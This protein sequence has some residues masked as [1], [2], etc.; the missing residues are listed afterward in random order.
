MCNRV[1][2]ALLPLAGYDLSLRPP[3]AAPAGGGGAVQGPEG[4]PLYSTVYLVSA[5]AQ[6][7]PC[8]DAGMRGM[9]PGYP[10]PLLLTVTILV[11]RFRILYGV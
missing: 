11:M 10:S 2:T 8:E 6:P 5:A 9:R 7:R 4:A 3:R 1:C